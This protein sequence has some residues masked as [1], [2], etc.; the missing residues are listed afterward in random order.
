MTSA[1]STE[2]VQK[3]GAYSTSHSGS[4]QV[5]PCIHGGPE[6]VCIN[7]VYTK[8]SGAGLGTDDLWSRYTVSSTMQASYP[9]AQT[10]LSPD[11]DEP[12]RVAT[13]SAQ[14]AQIARRKSFSSSTERGFLSWETL[15]ST[16][17]SPRL[18]P[19]VHK[20]SFSPSETPF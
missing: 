17:T 1:K 2:E 18:P 9:T 6:L 11:L 20:N 4:T 13:L 12:M 16:F 3:D 19:W 8:N 5:T 10:F 14:P 7:S 15:Q